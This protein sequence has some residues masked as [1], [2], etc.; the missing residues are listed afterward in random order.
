MTIRPDT[1]SKSHTV[2]VEVRYAETDQMGVVHHANYLVWFEIARTG[3]CAAT[4]YDYPSVERAGYLIL[5]TGVELRYHQGARYGDQVQVEAW[6]D[7][8][9]SRGMRFTYEVRRGAVRL[10]AGATS[11]LWVEA[12]SGRVRRI[13]SPW[14]EA[15]AAWT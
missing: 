10:A 11:H 14:K 5:V 9:D 13:P 1:T 12:E 7:R 8:L 6:L 3:L 4:G 15:F 2:D